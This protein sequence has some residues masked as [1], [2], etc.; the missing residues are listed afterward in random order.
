MEALLVLKTELFDKTIVYKDNIDYMPYDYT[1]VF[2]PYSSYAEH[3][4]QKA[5]SLFNLISFS[6]EI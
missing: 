4:P 6:T 2:V 5:L 3:P 1:T